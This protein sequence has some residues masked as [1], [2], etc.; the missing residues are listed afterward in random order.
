MSEIRVYDLRPKGE[1]PWL[2]TDDLQSLD[3]DLMQGGEYELR[4]RFVTKVEFDAL[5]DFD[6]W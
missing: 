5:P 1:G 6:G 4:V 3:D 2:T